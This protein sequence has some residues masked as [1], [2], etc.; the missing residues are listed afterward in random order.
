MRVLR[1]PCGGNS[2]LVLFRRRP[3]RGPGSPAVG[4]LENGASL[5]APWLGLSACRM[6]G[7]YPPQTQAAGGRLNP[8]T[9]KA[10]G[11][12]KEQG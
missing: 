4:L 6:Q 3:H 1:P 12:A 5:Q 10:R 11:A 8:G 2:A 7:L 9:Q